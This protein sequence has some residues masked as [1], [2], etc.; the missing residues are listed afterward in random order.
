MKRTTYVAQAGVIAAVYAVLTFFMIQTGLAS[1]PIQ[2]RL[3]EALTVVACVTPAAIPGLTLGSIVA[4]AALLPVFGPTALLDVIFGSLGTLLGALWM[5][6]F[7]KRQGLALLGPVVT[8]ALIVPAYL[9]V[10][11]A[12]GGYYEHTIFGVNI[13]AS[14]PAMYA[15]GVVTVAVGQFVSVYGFGLPL[16]LILKRLRVGQDDERIAE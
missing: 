7:R 9:P 5:W 6:R 11:L 1:G 12:A 10:I 4:N 13:A 15:F 3:S 2:F 16:L 8:N 14:W